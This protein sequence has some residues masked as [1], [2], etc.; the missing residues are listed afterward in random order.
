M[1]ILTVCHNQVIYV[2]SV[3]LTLKCI[4]ADYVTSQILT[5]SALLPETASSV[6]TVFS[7]TVESVVLYLSTAKE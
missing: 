2:C 1:L 7:S 5:V 3:N 6:K 4:S